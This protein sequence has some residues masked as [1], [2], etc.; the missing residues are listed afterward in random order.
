MFA[1]EEDGCRVGAREGGT[2]GENVG[3]LVSVRDG[4]MLHN[5][6]ITCNQLRIQGT[7]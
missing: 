6:P 4:D 1:G 2:E 3:V 5:A 7:E